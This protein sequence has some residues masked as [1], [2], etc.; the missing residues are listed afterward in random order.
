M[1]VGVDLDNTIICWDT[2]FAAVARERGLPEDVPAT[3]GAIKASFIDHDREDEWTLLQGEVYGAAAAKAVPFPG[4]RDALAALAGLGHQLVLVSHKT[5][6]PHRGPPYD[7]RGAAVDW[8]ITHGFVGARAF[9]RDRLFFESTRSDKITRIRAL[10]CDAFIDDLPGVL[11]DQSFPE[12]ATAVLFDPEGRHETF[13][14][15]RA[16]N[17]QAIPALLRNLHA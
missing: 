12:G 4:A 7:L 13:A 6:R 17:W 11:E 1:I 9:A 10:A 2:A 14:G 8:L 15:A 3:K 5:E 16:A